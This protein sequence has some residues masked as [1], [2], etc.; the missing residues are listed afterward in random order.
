MISFVAWKASTEQQLA[1]VQINKMKGI[2]ENVDSTYE[3]IRSAAI[4]IF[5][6]YLGDKSEQKIEVSSTAVQSLCI[7][8]RSTAEPP[9]DLWFDEIQSIVYEMFKTREDFLPTFRK[10]HQYI[11]LLGEL[12]L[13]QQ[14]VEEDNISLNSVDSLEIN[15]VEEKQSLF[16]EHKQ[17]LLTHSDSHLCDAGATKGMKHV[18]S[19]SDVTCVV[20][21]TDLKCV[22]GRENGQE[23]KTENGQVMKSGS[24]ILSAN[25]IQTGELK[26]NLII[27]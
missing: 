22:K 5:N 21:K 20:G 24:F 3:N 14:N 11:K 9:S 25:I 8:L 4:G 12:D 23:E 26:L 1:N 6:Q 18:R 27:Y 2:H 13:L 7:K 19:L 17:L 10:S 16:P 15:N